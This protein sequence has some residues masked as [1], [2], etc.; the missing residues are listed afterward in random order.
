MQMPGQACL[1]ALCVIHSPGLSTVSPAKGF[2]GQV[3]TVLGRTTTCLCLCL[4]PYCNC[5]AARRAML[6]HRDLSQTQ[7]AYYRSPTSIFNLRFLSPSR[8][9]SIVPPDQG[10]AV[11]G[12]VCMGCSFVGLKSF[13]TLSTASTSGTGSINMNP[14]H[15]LRGTLEFSIISTSLRAI[16]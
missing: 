3:Q 4:G 14:F 10:G 1:I 9:Q 12:G 2:G 16:D 11:L 7:F 13:D 8:L 5:S 6:F 15:A